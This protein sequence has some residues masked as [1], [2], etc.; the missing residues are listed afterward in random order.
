MGPLLAGLLIAIMPLYDV[1]W[2]D[3]LSF[4]VSAL[5]LALIRQ[6]FN[7]ETAEERTTSIRQDVVEGLRYVIGHPVLRNISLM[8]ALVNFV[9]S[10]TGTQLVLFA[11]Q[12]LQASDAQVG[13]LYSAGS[14]GIVLLSLA[15]GLLRKRWSFSTVALG[16]RSMASGIVQ[17]LFA[18]NTW[19]LTAL[20]L[21]ALESGLGVLFD[22]NT[23]SLRQAIVPNHMLGRVM[24]IAGVLAWSAIPVGTFLGGVAIERTGD[25]ALVYL[26][27]G[28]IVFLIPLCFRFTPLGRAER[29]LPQ[30][31]VEGEPV[32][33][34]A[35]V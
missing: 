21:W 18:V 15:A 11:Q 10:T 29:Y 32:A 26:V 5:S 28:V 14:V 30:P 17:V 12:R 27:I 8:M 20:V 4:G 24:S 19:Y 31:E 23:G 1:L 35:A 9:G 25:V 2:F 33:Q 16:R 7:T 6:A 34:P 13:Y 22:L 3:A